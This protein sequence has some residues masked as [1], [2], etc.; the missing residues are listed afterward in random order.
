MLEV[1]EKR[2]Y[3]SKDGRLITEYKVI[4]SDTQKTYYPLQVVSNNKIS[5][6]VGDGSFID[7]LEGKTSKPSRVDR[8]GIDG[9]F[10][11]LFNDISY[12]LT[13]FQYEDYME[14]KYSKLKKP[15]NNLKYEIIDKKS[16]QFIANDI[17]TGYE[18]VVKMENGKILYFYSD[19]FYPFYA[20]FKESFLNEIMT[21]NP[22]EVKVPEKI[23]EFESFKET[24]NSKYYDI[25]LELEK[26]KDTDIE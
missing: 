18:L 4:D 15:N 20:I 12:D 24:E 21:K 22:N 2:N 6:D 5:Q 26:F 1:L 19:T 9:Q 25:Y 16:H 23:E 3:K 10:E 11:K 7:Y 13:K 8:T 14:T 17:V